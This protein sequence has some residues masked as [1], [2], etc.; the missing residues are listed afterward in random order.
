MVLNSY[1]IC[2]EDIPVGSKPVSKLDCAI[3]IVAAV[4]E[5]QLQEKNGAAGISGTRNEE[6]DSRH[7]RKLPTKKEKVCCV[8]VLIEQNVDQ[9]EGKDSE[10]CVKC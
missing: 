10:R 6:T 4:S 8:C 9:L 2:N 3:K 5:E 1:I 7:L